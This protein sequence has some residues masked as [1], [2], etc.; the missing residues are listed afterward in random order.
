MPTDREPTSVRLSSAQ[1]RCLAHPLR[2]RLLAS[3]R[4]DGPLTSAR[5]ADRLGTNTGATSYHLRQLAEVGLVEEVED[6]GT[7][8]ERWWA[9]AHTFS[10]WH[11]TDFDDDPDDRAAAE[12][13]VDSYTRNKQRW[14][15]YWLA[16]RR[17]WSTEWRRAADFSDISLEVTPDELR[18]LTAELLEVVK[19]HRQAAL[20]DPDRNGDIARVLV[21]LEAFPAP[22]IHL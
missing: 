7:A 15:E 8:R 5:L 20:D 4:V 16:T 6:L 18:S 9:S 21:L 13:L 1:I 19:R 3:L 17:T 22:E 14:R 12:W 10:T 11:E 2:S